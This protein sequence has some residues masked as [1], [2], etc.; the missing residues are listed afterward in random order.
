[1]NM[2]PNTPVASSGF[3]RYGIKSISPSLLSQWDNAPAT[4]ILK[5]VFGIKGKSN[6]RM[7]RGDAVEAGMQVLIQGGTQD[8]ALTKAKDTFWLRAEGVVDDETEREDGLIPLMLDV[9]RAWLDEA[10]LPELLGSQIVVEGF[11]ADVSAPVWGKLDFVF[12]DGPIIEVKTTERAP[13][14]IETA[15]LSHRWQAAMYA[16][17]RGQPVTL[18]Y[19]TPK[20]S[21]SFT[22]EPG[23]PVLV[24]AIQTANAMDRLLMAHDE[25]Q[26]LISSLPLVAGSFYWDDD[27]IEAYQKAIDGDLLPLAGTGTDAL[28]EK[29]IITFGKHAGKHISDVPASYCDW[30]LDPRLSSGDT[31]DVPPALQG[32]IRSMREVA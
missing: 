6:A 21:V 12:F 11:L 22:V 18:L 31:F 10:G 9:A 5:R 23:D 8:E 16:E 30:L 19:I 13:S 26:D 15:S 28:H 24:S 20:K 7:W 27:L 25:G 3:A 4:L 32:A 14:R 1:M 17:L 29:G 2:Q